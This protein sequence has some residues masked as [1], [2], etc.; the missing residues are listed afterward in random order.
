MSD[1]IGY[2]YEDRLIC[3]GCAINQPTKGEEAEAEALP[4]G[5]TCDECW[6]VVNA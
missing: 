2:Y 1:V 6:V 5:F 3:V 4:N